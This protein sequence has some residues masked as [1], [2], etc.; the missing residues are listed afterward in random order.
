MSFVAGNEVLLGCMR[1]R[2]QVQR[3]VLKNTWGFV[4]PMRYI[5]VLYVGL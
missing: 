5:V 4:L 2:L 3:R 1:D